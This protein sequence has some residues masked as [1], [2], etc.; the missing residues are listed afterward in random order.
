[1]CPSWYHI[2][3]PL[4]EAANDPTGIK[5]LLNDALEDSFKELKNKVYDKTLL[6]HSDWTITSTVH[7]DDSDK[8]LGDFISH[9]NKPIALLS[10]RLSKPQRN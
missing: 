2:L 9:N 6:S 10:R 8:Q 4:S 7:I 5:I 3:A 1:M